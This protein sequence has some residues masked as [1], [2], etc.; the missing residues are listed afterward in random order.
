LLFSLAALALEG[1]A[2]RYAGKMAAVGVNWEW[3]RPKKPASP[4]DIKGMEIR[5]KGIILAGMVM[6][7][8]SIAVIVVEFLRSR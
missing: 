2:Y 4:E 8:F 5:L 6:P 1:L 3:P 7:V